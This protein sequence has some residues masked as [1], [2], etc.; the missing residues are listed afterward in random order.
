MKA[1]RSAFRGA[2][3]LVKAPRKDPSTIIQSTKDLGAIYSVLAQFGFE[4][5]PFAASLLSRHPWLESELKCPLNKSRL[6]DKMSLLEDLGIASTE[7]IENCDLLQLP[8]EGILGRYFC[9]A[10]GGMDPE[11]ISAHMLSAVG[12]DVEER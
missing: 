1:I 3:R 5:A 11:L 7:V 8:N 12:E 4:S 2:P 10:D 9:L 6:T